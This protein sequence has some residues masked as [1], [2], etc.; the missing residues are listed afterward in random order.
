MID[1]SIGDAVLAT[2]ALGVFGVFAYA[3]F[4]LLFRANTSRLL[5][6]EMRDRRG[7]RYWSAV[8][9]LLLLTVFVACLFISAFGSHA[10]LSEIHAMRWGAGAGIAMGILIMSV[11][12][13]VMWTASWCV[14]IGE[15]GDPA[16][17]RRRARNRYPIGYW[18]TLVLFSVM[19]LAGLVIL[20][21]S[22]ASAFG[23]WD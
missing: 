18:I 16:W 13:D 19:F 12:I 11:A 10:G 4:T 23:I 8:W 22:S 7:G 20:C 5:R 17:R 3:L 15:G 14:E 1:I 21:L 6:S 2:G 9:I